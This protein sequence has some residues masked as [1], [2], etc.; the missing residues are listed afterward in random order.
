[1]GATKM[2][3]R[4]SL[5]HYLHI[6]T[7]SISSEIEFVVLKLPLLPHICPVDPSILINRKSSF[8]ILGV[9]GVFLFDIYSVF[10]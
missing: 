4:L 2:K 6:K 8:L 3:L 9:S 1:M 10:E 5:K 7:R